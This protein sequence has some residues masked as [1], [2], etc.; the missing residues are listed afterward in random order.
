MSRRQARVIAFKTIYR[1]DFTGEALERLLD[2]SWLGEKKFQQLQEDPRGE[3]VLNFARWII[4]GT[5]EHL[6]EIDKKISEF[7][8]HWDISRVA[9][10]DLAILRISVFGLLYMTDIPASVTIDEAV[11]MAREFASP[12][13]YRFVNGVLDGVRKSL[14]QKG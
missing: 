6:E 12:D 5:L 14:M 13:S 1:F 2:F 7:L 11:E 4:T 9:R 8:Q 10:V 3:G